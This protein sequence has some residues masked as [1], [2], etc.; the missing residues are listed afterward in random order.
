MTDCL[1]QIIN[2]V[3]FFLWNSRS[4]NYRHHIVGWTIRPVKAEEHGGF[5]V[6]FD[7]HFE[8]DD[9]V[10]FDQVLRHP[11][12]EEVDDYKAY[13]LASREQ[14]DYERYAN[15]RLGSLNY[16]PSNEM[17]LSKEEFMEQFRSPS[18]L[19]CAPDEGGLSHTP[20]REQGFPRRNLDGSTEE[21]K[22]DVGNRK[23]NPPPRFRE[24]DWNP[25]PRTPPPL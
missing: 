3:A 6:M 8:R 18:D 7:I 15:L 20:S 17:N 4:Q 25:P 2:S 10:S 11:T 5:D 1:F 19:E 14:I 22:E 16:M 23:W 13:K 21:N 9:H 24:V 12:A